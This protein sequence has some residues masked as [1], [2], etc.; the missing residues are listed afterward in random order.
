M[1]LL[2]G[3]A[4]VSAQSTEQV[5]PVQR[6]VPDASGTDV[7][8]VSETVD[9]SSKLTDVTPGASRLDLSR[10]ETPASVDSVTQQ[11]MQD[12]GADTVIAAVRGVPGMTSA[13]RPGAPGVFSTRGFAENSIGLLFDG[14]RVQSSTITMRTYD[15]FTFERIDIL[16]GPASVLH[17]EGASVGAI[18]FVTRQPTKGASRTEVLGEVGSRGKVRLGAAASGGL[19]DRAAYAISAVG[20]HFDTDVDANTH[21]YSHLVGALRLSPTSRLD[22]TIEADWLHTDVDD[23]YW[24][25]PLVNGRIDDAIRT[26]NYNRSAN[27][28]YRDD[29]GWLRGSARWTFSPDVAYEGRIYRYQANRDWRNSYGFE[30]LTSDPALVQRRAVENLAYDHALWGTR[31]EV[32]LH[33]L[34]WG[35]DT[36]T[37][38]GAD[39]SW[40]DFSS[41]RS[42]GPRVT[43]NTVDPQSLDFVAPDRADDRRADVTQQALFVEHRVKPTRKLSIIGGLRASRLQADMARP[44]S[45]VAFRKHF[46]PVDGRVGVVYELDARH[47]VYAQ[48]AGG[49]EPIEAL[50]IIGP[51]EAGFDL[52]KSRQWEAGARVTRWDGRLSLDAA[53]YHLEKRKLTSTDPLDSTRTVQVGRQSSRGVEVALALTPSARVRIDA[54]LARL[55]ARYDEFFEGAVSRAG[56]VPAN[57]PRTVVN[58]GFTAT[59]A[60][61]MELGAFWY[62]VGRRAADTTN[63]VWMDSYSTLDPFVRWRVSKKADLT[64]RARNLFDKTY[65]DWATRA[66]GVTNVYFSQGRRVE[67]TLRLRS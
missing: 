10:R 6:C 45:G 49:S 53:V 3:P 18:N 51:A 65:T 22:A 54:N 29:V 19:G 59:P 17:G 37:V 38:V 4:A 30:V 11:T 16:R 31:H 50:L 7:P 21:N 39:A 43:V 12:R 58:A 28:V 36:R 24:G 14:I 40:T 1:E 44:A 5:A 2:A 35:L 15:A 25:T 8:C 61:R 55:G 62:F 56:N 32:R 34:L 20:N 60:G 26:F 52:A 67:L 13:V 42:Y 66:F 48:Y 27:N 33:T 9:V 57:V 41:P 47:A 23:A 64:L 46:T 63:S